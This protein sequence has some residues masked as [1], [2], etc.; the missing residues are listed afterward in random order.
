M[1]AST[2]VGRLTACGP[3]LTAAVRSSAQASID[4]REAARQLHD[5]AGSL[6]MLEYHKDLVVSLMLTGHDDSFRA[7]YHAVL[8]VDS[9]RMH[10]RQNWRRCMRND[11]SVE[12]P[13]LTSSW[14][15]LVLVRAI[16]DAPGST[17]DC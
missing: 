7:A 5:A 15:S 3:A 13:P 12:G 11:N 4:K 14:W 16:T 6:W 9:H 17:G 2:Y 1:T 8:G 10:R